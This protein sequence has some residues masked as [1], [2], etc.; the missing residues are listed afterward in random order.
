MGNSLGP[1]TFLSD[2]H[3][4]TKEIVFVVYV[5]HIACNFVVVSGTRNPGFGFLTT[6]NSLLLVLR[7][8]TFIT[9][10]VHQFTDMHRYTPTAVDLRALHF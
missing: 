9:V 3:F 4:S 2:L 10:V 8:T 5:T 7:P 6:P 1:S